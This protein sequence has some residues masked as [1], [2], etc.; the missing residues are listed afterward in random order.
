ME[1]YDKTYLVHSVQLERLL[2]LNLVTIISSTLLAILLAYIQYDILKP[3]LTYGLL[4][5]AL[6][7]NA[8]RVGLYQYYI[9]TPKDDHATIKNRLLFFRVGVFLS[10]VV[11]GIQGYLAFK[12]DTQPDYQVLVI[13]LLIG[14]TSGAVVSYAIDRVSALAYILFTVLPMLL[15]LYFF[16]QGNE[17]YNIMS[18]SAL[19]YVIYNS[20]SVKR[21]NERLLEA[22]VLKHEADLREQETKKLAFF[23]SLTDLPNRRLLKDRLQ[24]A[25]DVTRRSEKN[26]A[27]LFIDL[28]QF[29]QLNDTYGHEKGD[30][31]L[32][33]VAARLKDAVRESDTVA[34]LGG[35]EFV[36]MVE[37]LSSNL[38]D[39][40]VQLSLLANNILSKLTKP[41]DLD[42]ITYQ[43][44]C[45]VGI[46]IF[47][48]HGNDDDSLLR[49]ADAAMYQV[50]ERG[51][52]GA[53]I[54]EGRE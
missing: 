34:R 9:R 1:M 27:V 10:A 38:K 29:K 30:I 2:S 51:G 14:T 32:Q 17:I 6:V 23:D 46:A 41:F 18:A 22:I 31:L 37:N 8:T 40:E 12:L 54:F 4:A 3:T 48:E 25:I 11:W 50:K 53:Q 7:V 33:Q 21:V 52:N 5:T 24:H 13:Y 39:A 42:G 36:V 45:S 26:G 20:V 19:V 16:S 28:D 49:H 35:D 44:G 43:C 15:S 47:G